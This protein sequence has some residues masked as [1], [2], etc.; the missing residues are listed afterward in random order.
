MNLKL[1]LKRI[2]KDQN[3]VGWTIVAINGVFAVGGIV[4]GQYA[5]AGLNIAGGL[6]WIWLIE[7][8]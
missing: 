4:I 3:I 8:R 6:M 5:S 2:V 7:N 1:R